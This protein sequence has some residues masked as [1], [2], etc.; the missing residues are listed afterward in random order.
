MFLGFQNKTIVAVG[1][2]VTGFSLPAAAQT[3]PQETDASQ[4]QSSQ[5]EGLRELGQTVDTGIG[6]VGTRQT[7]E[8][9][10]PNLEPLGRINSRIENRIQNRIRNRIDRNYDPTANATSPFERAEER[11]RRG[12]SPTPR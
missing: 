2:A 6:E 10:A 1:L 4:T 3:A 12:S 7:R 8:D 5:G 9:A 11:N